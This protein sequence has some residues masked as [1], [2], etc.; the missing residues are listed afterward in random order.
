MENNL[1]LGAQSLLDFITVT[2]QMLFSIAI[3]HSIHIE[4]KQ[5]SSRKTSTSA[6]LTTQKPL[7]VWIT[8]NWKILKEVGIPGHLS[9]CREPAHEIPPMTRSWG[10]KPDGQGGSGFQGFRKDAPG[11]H[12][13][14]DI[15]LSDACLN[16]LP[17]NFCDTGWRPSPI[18]SQINQF[19]SLIN[20]FPRWWYFMRLSRVKGV[21]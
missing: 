4:K 3:S 13:K 21:F 12:L 1:G 9:C 10:R 20:K 11:A 2:L 14:D 15:C 5:E 6:L 17:P 7:T 18:S 16:R 19:R 8:T